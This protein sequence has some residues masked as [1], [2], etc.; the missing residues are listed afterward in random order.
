MAGT[1]ST[2]EDVEARGGAAKRRPE[3]AER[4]ERLAAALRANLVR[5]KAAARAAE[6]S[7][8]VRPDKDPPDEDAG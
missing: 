3:A 5:R 2:D 8:P 1:K 7:A 6:S 4:A